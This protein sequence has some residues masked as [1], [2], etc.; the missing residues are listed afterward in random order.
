MYLPQ[1]CKLKTVV[2]VSFSD[3][4]IGTSG[5][6]ISHFLLSSLA[7]PCHIGIDPDPRIRT[8]AQK[9]RL[10][11]LLF[12]SVTFKIATKNYL[13]F[14]YYFLKLYLHHFSKI[15]SHKKVTKQ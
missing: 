3:P 8:S 4:H 1:Q 2:F 12:S 15:K 7:D 6:L 14:A 10:R 5:N 13:F 9:I 11:I